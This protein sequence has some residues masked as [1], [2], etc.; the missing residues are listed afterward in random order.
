MNLPV[1]KRAETFF[2]GLQATICAGLAAEDGAAGF[3][4]DRWERPGGGGGVS[5]V[6]EDGG[7]FEKA[8]V[9]FSSVQG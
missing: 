2:Q 6:L 9:N 4:T 1:E 3:K 5:R 7:V 8:G